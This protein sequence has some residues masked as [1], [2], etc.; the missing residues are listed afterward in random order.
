MARQ[1]EVV[2]VTTDTHCGHYTGLTPPDW[3]WPKKSDDPAREKIAKY[4]RWAWKTY[5]SYLKELG[6]FTRSLVAL[7]S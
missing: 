3:W 6:P 7:N 4:Q 2:L 5:K 1:T